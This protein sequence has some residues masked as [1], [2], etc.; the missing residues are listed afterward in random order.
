MPHHRIHSGSALLHFINPHVPLSNPITVHLHSRS[1][2]AD[3]NY[4][5]H[6]DAI[7]EF[8]AALQTLHG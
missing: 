2:V 5:C 4:E 1:M 8:L 6:H 7:V 3:T